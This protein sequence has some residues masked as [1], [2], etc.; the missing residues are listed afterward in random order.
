MQLIFQKLSIAH[1]TNFSLISEVS[2]SQGLRVTVNSSVTWRAL[3]Q[4]C[5]EWNKIVYQIA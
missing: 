5:T 2:I 3:G 1:S 4:A